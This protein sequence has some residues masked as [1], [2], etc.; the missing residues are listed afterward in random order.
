MVMDGSPSAVYAAYDDDLCGGVRNNIGPF[1]ACIEW[2][3]DKGL[4]H[5]DDDLP[6]VVYNTGGCQWYLHGERHRDGDRPVMESS[7]GTLVWTKNGNYHR[8]RNLPA[9]IYANGQCE[10]WV[11]G[12]RTGTS[13]DPPPGAVFPGQLTKPARPNSE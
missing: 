1:T 2:K 10:W 12:S 9:L 4:L 11:D 6:A 8:N 3:D 13:A 5:R 7:E